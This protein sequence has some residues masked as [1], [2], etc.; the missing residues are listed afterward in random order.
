MTTQHP[1]RQDKKEEKVRACVLFSTIFVIIDSVF[2]FPSLSL[3]PLLF[4]SPLL[5]SVFLSFSYSLSPKPL[6]SSS[7]VPSSPLSSV[8]TGHRVLQGWKPSECRP[9]R[10][11]RES[12]PAIR[13][14]RR[15]GHYGPCVS[16]LRG[17][18]G[19][20]RRGRCRCVYYILTYCTTD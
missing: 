11:A 15:V 18:R 17:M 8:H 7:V 19:H 5:I 2:F 13:P 10:S 9:Q 1:Q 6:F 16:P 3:S 20:S 4:L 14:V 12:R